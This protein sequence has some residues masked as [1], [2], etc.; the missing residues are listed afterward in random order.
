MNKF[1]YFII[2]F[3]LFGKSFVIVFGRRRCRCC[4]QWLPWITRWKDVFFL[5]KYLDLE[6]YKLETISFAVIE[7]VLLP[8]DNPSWV[9][10][11]LRTSNVFFN[12]EE[13]KSRLH[14]L[15]KCFQQRIEHITTT[16]LAKWTMF[17]EIMMVYTE[18]TENTRTHTHSII[19]RRVRWTVY[20]VPNDRW[21]ENFQSTV[22]EG[23]KH[24]RW[25]FTL[26]TNFGM[27]CAAIFYYR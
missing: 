15:W 5:H 1:H 13:E 2:S 8:T 18:Y 6:V 21:W 7:L 23:I 4:F 9:M 25:Q 19:G 27:A 24:L 22:D 17:R 3:G 10:L 14:Q 11:F 20:M 12:N 26:L 16:K